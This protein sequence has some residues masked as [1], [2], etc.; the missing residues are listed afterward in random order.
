MTAGASAVVVVSAAALGASAFYLLLPKFIRPLLRLALALRYGFRVTGLEN[1]PKTGPV[2]FAAN[3]VTWIDGFILAALVPREG[4][5]MVNAGLV[6]LP[7]LKQLTIR[8]GI[9][10]VP[11]R[12]PRAIRMA[13]EAARALLSQGE[14]IGIFPEGQ[15]SRTGAMNPFYRGIEVILRGRDDVAVVPVALD[16]LWGSVFSRSGGLFFWKRPKG[17]RRT[18]RIAYGPPVAR[19][20]MAFAVRQ[21]LL[22]ALV[23][24]RALATA[25]VPLPETILADLPRWEHPELGL[26][27][28]STADLHIPSA[29][30]HQIGSKPGTVGQAVPGVALRAVGEDGL[31]LPP[32]TEGRLEALLPDRPGWIDTGRRGRLDPDGFVRLG[33]GG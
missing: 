3:H 24:A 8:A 21:A 26:L 6:N 17:L 31:A 23:H 18:V 28:G 15:I 20:L 11:Y 27:T 7:V 2:L 4:K 19:P 10:P 32:G 14:C 29:D 12:G 16:G 33:D 9:I 5:A 13:I 25:P 22:E 1:I 30:V